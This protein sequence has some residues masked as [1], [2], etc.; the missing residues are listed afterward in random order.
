MKNAFIN[1]AIPYIQLTEPGGVPLIKLNSDVTVNLWDRWDV[2]GG[3]MKLKELFILL[4][5]KYKVFH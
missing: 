3:S 5:E 4:E 1:L 2:K